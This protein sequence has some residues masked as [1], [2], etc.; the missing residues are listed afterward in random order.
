MAM[1][2]G[3]LRGFIELLVR[4]EADLVQGLRDRD[5]IAIEKSPDQMYELQHAA[6]LELAVQK[7]SHESYLLRDVRS[8]LQRIQDGTFG[9]CIQCELAISPR[10]LTAVPWAPLC[11]E[12]QEAADNVERSS[13]DP[14]PAGAE[15]NFQWNASKVMSREK[16]C[17]REE[18]ISVPGGDR[19]FAAGAKPSTK[20]AMWR[21]LPRRSL[22]V[23]CLLAHEQEAPVVQ[24]R[25][26]A[27]L[28]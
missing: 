18:T 22:Q 2:R 8:A 4:K 1:A 5:D 23:G 13:N 9:T 16:N 15:S 21:I 24:E 27:G 14:L 19:V 28:Q 10:R 11:I 7:L 25:A 17:Q 12:C 3:A 20:R 26:A 6:T